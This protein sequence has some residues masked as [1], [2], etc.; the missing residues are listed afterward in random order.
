MKTVW[1]AE[2]Y[3]LNP[4]LNNLGNDKSG[5]HPT[6]KPIALFEYL[7]KL[8]PTKIDLVLD[9]QHSRKWVSTVSLF[10]YQT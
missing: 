1:Y 4:V 3:K 9:Q 8:T 2:H 5:L 10:E 6:Q 7:I